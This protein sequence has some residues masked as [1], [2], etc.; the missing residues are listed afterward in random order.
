MSYNKSKP[1]FNVNQLPAV[2]T[3]TEAG[4]YLRQDSQTL[5]KLAA[6]GRFPA[7]KLDGGTRWIVDRDDLLVYVQQCKQRHN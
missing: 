5:A 2:L 6:A 1:I 4:L 3:L 7:Y